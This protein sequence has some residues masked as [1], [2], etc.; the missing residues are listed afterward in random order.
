MDLL[1]K[2]RV[3]DSLESHDWH[4]LDFL[5]DYAFLCGLEPFSDRF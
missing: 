5:S 3:A 1:G 2:E 4:W